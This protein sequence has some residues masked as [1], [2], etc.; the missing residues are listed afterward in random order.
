MTGGGE[1]RLGPLEAVVDTGADI[2]VI[3]IHYLRQIKAKRIS[4]GKARSLWGDARMVDIYAVTLAVN[5]L[6]VA[7][8]QA[9]ADDQGE[10][11]VLGRQVLNRLKIVLDG[12]AAVM[13]IVEATP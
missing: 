4:R 13:E 10:E 9:L 1:T 12:P 3:P 11:I 7:A 8:L 6:Q 5:G 2:T